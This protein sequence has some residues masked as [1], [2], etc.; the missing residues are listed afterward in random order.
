LILLL[1]TV[2]IFAV[3]TVMRQKQDSAK[4]PP[5]QKSANVNL[6]SSPTQTNEYGLP[7][8][9]LQNDTSLPLSGKVILLDPGHGGDDPGAVYPTS[10]PLYFE[11][12]VNLELA[13][14]IKTE[15]E[16][17]GA[18]VILFRD[19]N[20]WLSL[21][22]RPAMAHLYAIDYLKNTGSS[23]FA[24]DVED[25]LKKELQTVLELQD[26]NPDSGGMG[27]MSG[28]G[29]GA[30]LQ[31]LMKMEY[32]IKDILYVSVHCNANNDSGL[33]GTQ[34]YYVTDEAIIESE[35]RLS[36][37]DPVYFDRPAFPNRDPFYGR[38][39]NRN[40][41]LAQSIYDAVTARVPE[42]QTNANETVSQNFAV[43]REHGLTGVLVETAFFSNDEDRQ[44]LMDPVYQQGI[45]EGIAQGC[46]NFFLAGN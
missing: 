30:D 27:I 14:L 2:V 12:E 4:V 23:P 16:K 43:L 18:C 31:L 11:K 40:Q 7:A 37:E 9:T 25:R 6:I 20:D 36:R 17:Q 39:G 21:Y 1:F 22:S 26:D 19:D 44:R 42:L 29:A 32:Q 34:V 35:E 8:I 13:L 38:D 46:S 41:L 33:H 45:A 5:P 24:A 3:W 10:D 28:T 15:L